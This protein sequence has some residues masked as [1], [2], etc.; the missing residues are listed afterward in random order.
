M[1][2][3]LEYMP[4][5]LPRKFPFWGEHLGNIYTTARH[6]AFLKVCPSCQSIPSGMKQLLP[7]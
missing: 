5:P 3:G 1:Q 2:P 6:Q 4:L 7:T